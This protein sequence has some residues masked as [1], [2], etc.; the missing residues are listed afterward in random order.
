MS[1]IDAAS[2]LPVQVALILASLIHL[3]WVGAIAGLFTAAVAVDALGGAR[4]RGLA[5]VFARSARLSLLA[6]AGLVVTAS[7]VLI[8]SRVRYPLLEQSGGYWAGALLPLAIGLALLG[9]FQEARDAGRWPLLRTWIGLAG[10]GG[11][12]TSCYV[13]L[14]GAGVVL[15]PETWGSI[16]PFYRFLPTWSG[17]GRFVEFTLIAFAGTGA[18]IATAGARA[19]DARVALFAR[20]FGLGAALASLF[21]LPAAVLFTQ[22]NLPAIALS[23]AEWAVAAGGIALA[24][25][26][27]WLAAAGLAA[28]AAPATRPMAAA[29]ALLV[30]VLVAGDHLAREEAVQP[31]VLAGAVVAPA[32]PAA[33]RPVAPAA[34]T[35]RLAAGK[36]VFDRVCSLCHRFDAKLVGPPLDATVPK[37]RKDPAALKA[38]LRNPVK[39]D[40]AYPVMPK[41]AITEQEIDAVAA[42]L[43]E[44][45]AP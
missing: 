2:R 40:P 36:A 21:A 15:Q 27:A 23:P 33:P 17:T 43:L 41:P 19:E 7:G 31:A 5:G 1:A 20:R 30:G 13:L 12:V 38:F 22:L 25:V 18:L 42:F 16:D 24:G 35:G 32:A 14:S 34:P 29:A 28:D 10:V 3:A 37:Y 45:A 4:L 8:L 44:K 6:A 26:A 11:V 9:A 39:K